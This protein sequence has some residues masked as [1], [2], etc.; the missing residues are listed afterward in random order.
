[1]IKP[2][3]GSLFAYLL[4]APWWVS[5]LIALGLFAIA[6]VFL[7]A[8]YAVATTLPF[9]GIGAWVA[10]KQS[11]IPGQAKVDATMERLRGMAWN[12]FSVVVT[13]SFRG[14]GYEVAPARGVADFSLT[15]DGYVTLLACKRWKAAQ[16]GVAPLRELADARQA[17]AAR[18]AIYV[19]TGAVAP[20]AIK[21]AAANDITVLSDL[22]L[23]QHLEDA[24]RVAK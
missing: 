21:F 7:P 23:T 11:K 2:R 22:G 16:T 5:F 6:R 20:A 4:R 15:R 18:A 10:W 3:D 13:E 14:R 1:M 12:E 19:T 8:V 24:R 9:L 17:A